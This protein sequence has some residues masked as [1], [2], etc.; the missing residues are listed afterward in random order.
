MSKRKVAIFTG[1]RAGYGLQFP[2]LRAVAA[3]ERLEPYLLVGG[4]HL[5]QDFG[6][7]VAEIEKDGF[8]IYRQVQMDMTQDTLYATAQAIGTGVLS[9]SR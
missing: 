5:Q 7:T 4:A 6:K 8:Q 9:I 1:N 2:I 3:D